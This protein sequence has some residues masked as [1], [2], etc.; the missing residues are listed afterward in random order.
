MSGIHKIQRAD[1]VPFTLIQN[2]IVRNP[3]ISL[4]GFR[5]ITYLMSHSDGYEITYEQI[6]RETGLG[7]YAINS[8]IKNLEELGYLR[9]ERP[10]LP[11]GHFAAK[12]WTILDPTTV[13]NSTVG[14]STMDESTDNKKNTVIKKN[15][16]KKYQRQG[17]S[18]DWQPGEQLRE[19]LQNK[20]PSAN[21]DECL[22]QMKLFYV[23]KGKENT[24]KDIGATFRNWMINADKYA[25]GALSRKDERNY[26]N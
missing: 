11:N 15:N 13:G 21:L 2:Q 26:L 4:P 18:E 24:I 5:L 25:K 14:N 1:N 10:K 8:G 3:A 19:E 9:T 7:R 12:S 16:I 6:E 22:E 17:F 20:Y 23:G